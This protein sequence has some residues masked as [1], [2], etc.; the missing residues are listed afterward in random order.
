MPPIDRELSPFD[1]YVGT[2]WGEMEPEHATATLAIEDHHRQPYGPVH[3]GVLCTLAESTTSR[4]TAIN[5]AADEMR[6]MGQSNHLS[7]LRPMFEGT[8]Q[9]EAFR[10]HG[11]RTSWVWDVEF[12]DDEGRLCALSRVIVAVRRAQSP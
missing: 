2:V 1:E 7:F 3:G 11:G 8:I 6:A 5:V 10:R 9:V 4:A 12:T